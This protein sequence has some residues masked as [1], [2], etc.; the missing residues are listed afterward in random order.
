MQLDASGEHRATA[1]CWKPNLPQAGRHVIIATMSTASAIRS[2]GGAGAAEVACE[3]ALEARDVNFFYGERHALNAVSF[4]IARGEIFGFLGPNG[5]GKTTLFRVLST[6]VPCQ[7]GTVR[8]LG[9][10][11]VRQ[12]AA[13]QRRLGVVFQHPSVDEKLTVRENLKHHGHLYGLR[14]KPL[15]ARTE[16]ILARLGLSDRIDDLVETLSGGLRRRTELAKALLHQ[17]EMLLLDEPSTGLDPGARREFND[18]LAQLRERDGVTVVLTTHY[19]EEAERCDRIAVMHEGRI[20]AMAPPAELKNQIGGDVVV[21][22]SSGEPAALMRKLAQEL[23]LKGTLVDGTIR[24]EHQRGHEL[25]REMVDALGSEIE[26]VSFGKPTLEDVFVRLTGRR[27]FAN[28]A[29]NG[30]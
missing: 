28:G 19:M 18:Y 27:F 15:R 29:G 12:K 6:L 16:E 2:E 24:I 7:S 1:R 13:I 23:G 11:L 30:D 17:P 10:D 20:V 9:A 26:A 5:G 14:G 25:V 3:P 4:S 22:R 21:V 8:M